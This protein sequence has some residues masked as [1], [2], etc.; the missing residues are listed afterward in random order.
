MAHQ[1]IYRKWRPTVFEDIVGQ[2]HI[3]K[4][5]KNQ[6]IN[7]KIGHAYLFCGTRGT[8][9]TT[10]AKV[11]SR[12]V[13]CLSPKDGSPCNECEI[14][15]G[16]LDGS[17]MDIT[18]I[19]A[20]SNNGVDNIR[21]IREDVQYVSANSK[22]TVYIIDEV[23]MLSPG[24]FNA[25]LKT[26]EEPPENVI[27]ILA[28]TEAH[29]V[30]QTILSRCQRFDFKRIRPE[31]II[32]RMKEIAHGEGL[33][34]S[35]D[36]YELLARLA[37]GSMRDGL[38]V[39]ERVVSSTDEE[40]TAE[41]IT[42]VLGISDNEQLMS[43][44]DAIIENDINR[45]FG[46]IEK[47]LSDGKDI[48]VFNDSLIAHFRDLL[49]LKISADNTNLLDYSAQA[50]VKLKAQAQKLTFE[51]I[52][53]AIR[54]LTTA[55]SDAKWQK[56]PR[57]IFELAYVKLARP[58]V[59]SSPDAILDR[60]TTVEQRLSQG[61]MSGTAKKDPDIEKRLSELEE[62][63]KN[64]DITVSEKP[65]EDIKEKKKAPPRLYSPIPKSELHSGNP[66][67]KIA[68]NWD[69]TV[70]IILGANPKWFPVLNS[71]PITID[72]EGIILI[73]ENSQKI[74]YEGAVKYREEIID[75]FKQ[76]TQS[77]YIIKAAYK[78]DIED[79][80]ID[81]WSLP[82]PEDTEAQDDVQ[83]PEISDP[84][85]RLKSEFSAI[86]EDADETEFIDYDSA[87]DNFSQS[88]LDD[89][90]DDEQSE[91]YLEESEKKLAYD[92]EDN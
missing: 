23:H 41:T 92:E 91:E 3:T 62:K 61:V 48:K 57:V 21:E 5:L 50:M 8:G 73:Y 89:T 10:C 42:N 69:N 4:T 46:I 56:A 27:F 85:D 19:D 51:K 63:L 71:I 20:A 9:K 53:N 34:I 6:I 90:D 88:S 16:I 1:A 64:A 7:N 35:D 74:S 77:S 29:K 45:I 38:S 60:L 15:R 79:N 66:I 52:S 26:L 55:Q 72:N 67:V 47:V 18:E 70:R 31:D 33:K 11:F 82:S 44:T 84:L 25:L 59:D 75:A 13:N 17:I 36:G 86:V 30:P 43:I 12:A 68:K 22:Y 40:I 24:A 28:T 76:V 65:K 83:I 54:V 32:L 39:L 80:I 58:E 81:F 14:C 78:Q 37:D 49:V 2:E 87:D